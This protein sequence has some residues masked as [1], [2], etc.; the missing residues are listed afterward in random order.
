MR[1]ALL[2]ML[3]AA[4]DPTGWVADLAGSVSRDARG[5][6]AVDLSGTWVTDTDLDRLAAVPNLAV[7]KLA[8]TRITDQGMRRL[9][10]LQNIVSLDL[11]Y[12]EQVTDEGLTALKGWKH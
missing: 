5:R 9:K 11:T 3:A 8:H 4:A 7:L 12:A 2:F 1:T 6:V 10:P